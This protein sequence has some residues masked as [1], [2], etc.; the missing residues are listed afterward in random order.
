MPIVLLLVGNNINIPEVS[1]EGVIR[2]LHRLALF[3]YLFLLL[4]LFLIPLFYIY[5]YQKEE[6]GEKGVGI[7]IL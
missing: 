1:E 4:L 5:I 3:I 7:W 6:G 2:S